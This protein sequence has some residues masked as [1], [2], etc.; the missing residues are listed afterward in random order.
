MASL[1]LRRKTR[2]ALQ[3]NS[4]ARW[5]LILGLLVFLFVACPPLVAATVVFQ[6]TFAIVLILTLLA[7]SFIIRSSKPLWRY[8]L[9]VAF[10]TTGSGQSGKYFGHSLL[11]TFTIEDILCFTLA[12]FVALNILSRRFSQI[13]IPVPIILTG[14]FGLAMILSVTALLYRK[15]P[16][17]LGA[18]WYY[19]AESYARKVVVHAVTGFTLSAGIFYLISSWQLATKFVN[20][21]I[22][23]A[24]FFSLHA[25]AEWILRDTY[26]RWYYDFFGYNIE[27][28]TR[29]SIA[30]NSNRAFGLFHS[31]P[32]LA[33]WLVLFTPVIL[34]A[35]YFPP[36][37]QRMLIAIASL[38][39]L[40]AGLFVT[41]SR[42]PVAA[43]LFIV[44]VYPWLIGRMKIALTGTAIVAT[45]LL[46]LVLKGPE[47]ARVLPPHN[48]LERIF[49]PSEGSALATLE[50]RQKV[51]Y[52]ALSQFRRHPVLGMAPEQFREEKKYRQLKN[53]GELDSAHSGYFQTLAELGLVGSLAGVGL[54]GSTLVYG[55]RAIRRSR[56]GA[57]RGL[58][59]ACL[60]SCAALLITA[61][62]EPAFT[63]NRNYYVFCLMLGLMLRIP[64]IP[65]DDE[66]QRPAPRPAR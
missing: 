25:F 12:I 3:A 1:K 6:P 17:F 22:F 29:V 10:I 38:C 32:G 36:R 27:N 48:L 40:F 55:L 44:A 11:S 26:Y 47:I 20:F 43:F 62:T 39:A 52:E 37:R 8:F 60:C 4:F 42:A 9:L 45:L 61:I 15:H 34:Y 49:A 64:D 28:F 58:V 35:I 57:R 33:A 16:D 30:L 54:Y 59:A 21:L 53:P 2:D 24:V 50:E 51:W 14:I 41:G 23:V 65:A 56:P 66:E 18:F 63:I 31:G 13:P 19:Y 5:I 7:I 46:A